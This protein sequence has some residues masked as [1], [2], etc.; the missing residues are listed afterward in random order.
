MLQH[1]TTRAG[2]RLERSRQWC[3][4]TQAQ[5]IEFA[6]D[7]EA[8]L[9]GGEFGMA[10]LCQVTMGRHR[11]EQSGAA[12]PARR[13]PTLKFLFQEEGSATI[14]QGGQRQ[15][16]RTGQWCAIRKDMD[17][18][19]DAPQQSRQLTL[20]LPCS[21]MTAPDRPVSWWRT[22]RSFLQGPAHILHASAAASLRSGNHLSDGTR[23]QIGAQLIALAQMSVVD[24]E[25]DALPDQREE[26]RR[27]VLEFIDRNLT[28]PD[29]GIASIAAAFNFSKRTIHKLFESEEQTVARLIWDH[30]LDRCCADMVDPAL[31]SRSLTDIAHYWGFSDSQH[32][33]RAFRQRFGMTARDYRA[34]AIAPTAAR[35]VKSL[36]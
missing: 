3:A 26:R 8:S 33:S 12:S 21:T 10:R 14:C 32:F 19:L 4:V 17:F 1:F 13:S 30:R 7:R 28:E 29:L 9:R 18:V 6:D 25:A 31:A 11:V 2:N 27:A 5:Q 15:T 36:R 24:S 34:I 16:L 22:S 23:E 20:T 35:P